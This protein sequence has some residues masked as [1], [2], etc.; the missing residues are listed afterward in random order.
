MKKTIAIALLTI[1]SVLIAQAETKTVEGRVARAKNGSEME[2][3]NPNITVMDN[4][5]FAVLSLQGQLEGY[6]GK[7][8][9]V[10]GDLGQRPAGYALFKTID[11]VEVIEEQP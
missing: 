7:K 3:V 6:E 9:R 10:T 8:V 4:K 2:I 11:K 5:I 1:S